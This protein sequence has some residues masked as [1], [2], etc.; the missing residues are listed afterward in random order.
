M[1]DWL[2]ICRHVAGERVG[3]RRGTGRQM[4]VGDKSTGR[5]V[6]KASWGRVD[7]SAPGD[8]PSP[9]DLFAGGSLGE[10]PS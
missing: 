6:Y 2:S 7:S 1:K 10:G 8:R 3:A 9:S 4:R 5:L